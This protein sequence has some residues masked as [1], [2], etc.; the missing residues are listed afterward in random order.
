MSTDCLF[1]EIAAGKTPASVVY[2]DVRIVAFRDIHPVA[3]V[4][5]LLIP[6]KHIENVTAMQQDDAEILGQ[7]LLAAAKIAKDEN[8]QDGYRLVTNNGAKAGQSVYHLHFH[9]IGGRRMSWPPG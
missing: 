6:R 1:C 4:H 2:Q 7:L 5:I 9:L 8:I 3:P